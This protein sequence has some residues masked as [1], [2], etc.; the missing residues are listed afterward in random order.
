MQSKSFEVRSEYISTMD[1]LKKF[2]MDFL[3]KC[4]TQERNKQNRICIYIKDNDSP[5]IV[6]AVDGTVLA[7]KIDLAPKEKIAVYR[8]YGG[9]ELIEFIDLQEL[10]SYFSG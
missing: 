3:L 8:E 10:S 4:V 6:Q 1:L 5:A 7:K 9:I 2:D